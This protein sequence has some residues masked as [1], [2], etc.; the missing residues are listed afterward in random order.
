[1]R[2]G[3]ARDVADLLR[4]SVDK[5][6]EL[7]Q[8]GPDDGGLPSLRSIGPRLRFDL[9]EVEQWMRGVQPDRE[10]AAS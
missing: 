3:T 7:A 4:V 10:E 6:Y 1:M 9:D 2:V 5:V 8:K